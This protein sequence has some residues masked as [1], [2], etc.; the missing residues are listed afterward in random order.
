[1]KKLKRAARIWPSGRSLPTPGLAAAAAASA[2]ESLAC[3]PQHQAGHVEQQPPPEEGGR[4]ALADQPAPPG[5]GQRPGA[6]LGRPA[7]NSTPARLPPPGV[8][9][10]LRIAAGAINRPTH[11]IHTRTHSPRTAVCF[12]P[13]PGHVCVCVCLQVSKVAAYAYSAISQI[14]VDAKE[15]LVVQFAIP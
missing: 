1:M 10:G 11:I 13:H 14:K 5:A 8:S 12:L 7:G 4:P 2:P 3:V 9:A 15:D 6:V